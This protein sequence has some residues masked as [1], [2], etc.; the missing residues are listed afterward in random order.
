V[1][2]S[3]AVPKGSSLNPDDKRLAVAVEDHPYDYKDFEGIIP[4]GNYGA[5]AVIIWDEGTYEPLAPF[6]TKA[7]MEQD[8]WKQLKAGQIKIKLKGK[9]LKGEFVLVRIKDESQQNWLLIKHKDRY[10]KTSDI[11]SQ[12]KSVRSKKT[13]DD[14]SAKLPTSKKAVTK[15]TTVAKNVKRKPASKKTAQLKAISSEGKP[16]PFDLDNYSPMLATAGGTPFDDDDWLF[17]IKWDGYRALAGKKADEMLLQS[18]NNISFSEKFP[19]VYKALKDLKDDVIVDGEIVAVDKKGVPNFNALQNWKSNAAYTLNYFIFDLLWLNGK[20]LSKLPLK[21]RQNLLT[22]LLPQKHPVLKPS[23]VHEASGTEFFEAAK[24]MALEGIIAKKADSLY[25]PGKRTKDW[26]KIK[27]HN[28]QEVVICGYTKKEGSPRPFSALLLGVYEK[29]QLKYAGKVGTGFNN[30]EQKRLLKAFAPLQRKASPYNVAPDLTKN[31]RFSRGE[32]D[33]IFWLQAKL[34]C[35]INFTEISAEG[36]FRHPSYI[37]LRID[38]E[39]KAVNMEKTVNKTAKKTPSPFIKTSHTGSV[40]KKVNNI[41][42]E[43][44]NVDKVLWP[45]EGY[46]KA[47]M[48]NHYDKMAKY[49]LPYLKNRPQSLNRFPNGINKANFYQKDVTDKVPDWV[50]QYPYKA[51][52]EK[53]QKNYMLCNNKA[54][55]LYMANLGAIEMNPWSSTIDKPENPTWCILDIDPDKT[56]TFEQVITTANTIYALL[57]DLRIKA[58]SKTSGSTGIHIYIPLQNQYTYEQSQLIAQWIAAQVNQELDFTSIERMTRKRKGKI[59]IDYLQNRPGATLAAPYSIR[60]KP[61]ATV[62]MPLEWEELQP[63]LKMSD[64]T[65]E[66]AYQRVKDMGDLFKPVLGKGVNLKRILGAIE[67][68]EQQNQ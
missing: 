15:K 30:A 52:G 46:T 50:E 19:L 27:V 22:E 37:A 7:E 43:L 5:G 13:I 45:K 3:W 8:L 65:I 21:A 57:K 58:Y 40:I 61:G 24:K 53:Q 54:S 44:T 51:K 6:D 48:L 4:K 59:Y 36:I 16:A 2:K 42:L 60:P 62:S 39:A 9:K 18:R 49:I 29:G 31:T 55:L 10:A 47:D 56:N 20:D 63:G 32:K 14:L 26:L 11:T 25:Y 12:D 23:F 35:E 66:N 68:W 67:R 34:V 1:L 28:R 38:K 64:F 17:E 33:I 41:E